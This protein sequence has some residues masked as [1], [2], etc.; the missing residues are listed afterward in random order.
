MEKENTKKVK[1]GVKNRLLLSFK[2]G[3][4]IVLTLL[5]IESFTFKTPY[6]IVL[7]FFLV[8]TG[9]IF[10]PWL[11]NLVSLFKTSITTKNKWFI[12]IVSLFLSAYLITPE[13]ESYVRCILPIGLIII[14]WIGVIIY[15]KLKESS[16]K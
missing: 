4:W 2:S 1:S 16:K 12:F 15:R 7:G 11:D 14:L 8:S 9:F 5:G 3:A 13:E 6:L 10:F